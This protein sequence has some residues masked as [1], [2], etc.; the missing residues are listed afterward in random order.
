M[1]D[2]DS[3]ESNIQVYVDAKIIGGHDPTS[4]KRTLVAFVVKD[5]DDLRRAC[6]VEGVGETDDAEMQA[7]AFAIR[8]LKNRFGKFTILCD[9]ESV[10]SEILRGIMRPR[11]RPVLGEIHKERIAHPLIEVKL[12]A[13]NPAHKLLNQYEAELDKS[14]V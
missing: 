3:N 1:N 9:H 10:V 2:D 8:E 11:S 14:S 13:K 12:L 5:S 4:K 7:V 6:E